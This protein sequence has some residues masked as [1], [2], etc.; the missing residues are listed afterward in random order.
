MHQIYFILFLLVL[1]IRGQ[2]K[3]TTLHALFCHQLFIVRFLNLVLVPR[4]GLLNHHAPY[5]GVNVF[6]ISLQECVIM[7][8]AATPIVPLIR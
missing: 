2:S 5:F 7:D 8:A 6:V 3:R 1:L 4:M